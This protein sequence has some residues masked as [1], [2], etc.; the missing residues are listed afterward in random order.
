VVGAC[1]D[2]KVVHAWL[3]GFLYNLYVQNVLNQGSSEGEL[4]R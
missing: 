1:V 2:V 3:L 4:T